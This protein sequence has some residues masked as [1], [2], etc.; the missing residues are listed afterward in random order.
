MKQ[1]NIYGRECIKDE[2]L[3]NEL[4]KVPRGDENGV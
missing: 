4:K 3:N 2:I 1:D